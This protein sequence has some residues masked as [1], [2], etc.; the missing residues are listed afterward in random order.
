MSKDKKQPIPRKQY[1]R[2]RRE[3]FH[4]EDRE[5]RIQQQLDKDQTNI[6][7]NKNKSLP[8]QQQPNDNH[9]KYYKN[10][11]KDGTFVETQN[12]EHVRQTSNDDKHSTLDDEQSV[13]NKKDKQIEETLSENKQTSNEKGNTEKND[14]KEKINDD[15]NV[16]SSHKLTLPEEQQLSRESEPEQ[17]TKEKGVTKDNSKIRDEKDKSKAKSNN[18]N[19][20]AESEVDSNQT[21]KVNKDNDNTLG[22]D[23][24]NLKSSNDDKSS[25][26]KDKHAHPELENASDESQEHKVIS[27]SVPY[28]KRHES[29]MNK[30]DKQIH[31]H[32][33]KHVNNHID[34]DRHQD[35][36]NKN[37]S[38]YKD[39]EYATRDSAKQRNSKFEEYTG[40]VKKFFITYWPQIAI[41]IGI[42]LLIIILNAIFNNVN[43]NDRFGDDHKQDKT[44]YTTTM[45]N[46]NSSVK[47][48][49]TVEND[50]SRDTTVPQDKSG[51][52]NEVGSGVIYKKAGNTVYIVTNAHVVGDKS[53]Q[54]ITFPNGKHV[55]G[56]VLGKDQWSDLAVV[57]AQ[58]ADDSLQA[59]AI[60]DSNNLVLG[61]P[62]LVVGNPLGV[63]FKS[64]VSE[65]I[66]SGLNRQVPVDFDKDNKYDMLMKAFQIDAS[67]NPGNS[68]GAVVNR[69]GK[70]IGVVSV[71]IDMQNVENMAFAIPVNE[72]QKITKEL[73]EKG[74]VKYPE[75]G[76]SLKNVADLSAS[77]R[78]SLRLP[79]NVSNGVVVQDVKANSIAANSGIQ[80]NDVIVSLDGK[81]IEDNLRYRQVIYNHRED[82]KTLDT[83]VFRNG[84]EENIKLKLK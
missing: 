46:A 9:K 48:V 56:K 44:E 52:E 24:K 47:S 76:I 40:L 7:E 34:K 19:L 51:A 33:Q 43:Q 55:T 74:T 1:R 16:A 15:N 57:K 84:Q 82:L 71:K 4:N 5:Q 2:K 66:I 77:E 72:V 41:V 18:S 70:L 53:N 69:D 45:K 20:K 26:V 64:T 75:T 14:Y 49:V 36:N 68:G 3:F 65:G 13:E 8:K 63:D 23:E 29:S 32:K 83:K 25:S 27:P 38:L 22:K 81:L 42:I 79:N 28:S 6:N 59:I 58:S 35:T 54:K 10:Q 61:E 30:E 11:G 80:K 60:G 73:E 17:N 62:I 67:V 78:Q 31:N 50:T 37:T 21:K 39:N 12:N